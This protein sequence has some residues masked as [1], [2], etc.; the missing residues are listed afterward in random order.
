METAVV[1]SDTERSDNRASGEG[2]AQKAAWEIRLAE[3]FELM[4]EISLQT[5]PQAMVKAYGERVAKLYPV[6]RRISLSR[7][8]LVWPQ[9]RVTRYSEWQEEIDPWKEPQK[10]PLLSGGLLAELIY[11]N[12]PR[13]ID[14]LQLAGDDPAG[15][16][17][18]GQRSIMAIP[19]FD[20]GQALN[21]VVSSM[22]TPAGFD[23]ERFPD[24]VWLANLFGRAT[25]NLVLRKEIFEAYRLVDRELRVVGEIQ[26]SLLPKEVPQ[27]AGLDVAA[28][29]QTSQQAGGD[30]YDFFPLADGKWGLLIADVSG[31]G[32]PAAVM[33][34]I[35]HSIAHLYPGDPGRP[36]ELLEFVNRHL[37]GRYL[38]ESSAFVTAFYGIYDPRERTLMHSSAGHNPPRLL[39]QGSDTVIGLDGNGNMPMGLAVDTR[40]EDS[41][42][43]LEAGDEILLYTDGVTEAASASGEMFGTERVDR[44]LVATRGRSSAE[45]VAAIVAEL[46]KFTGDAPVSDDRSLVALR[47][48]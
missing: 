6:D 16:Y 39:S 46:E 43:K 36:G 4:R 22:S 34:A 25:Q 26:R 7:R 37:A 1:T 19:M 11:G 41:T 44:V 33:M 23:R 2:T 31:H 30:Y 20:G 47:L 18:A 38:T 3:V 10:L 42:V 24:R 13:I 12:E 35:T 14:D 29:Y 28:F 27:I 5:E 45:S 40:Y 15:P 21:M 32:T 48:S 9:Y 17:L 8:G